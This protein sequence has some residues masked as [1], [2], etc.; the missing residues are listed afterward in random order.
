MIRPGYP[1]AGAG[2]HQAGRPGMRAACETSA[3]AASLGPGNGMGAAR[4][5]TKP[6]F[7]FASLADVRAWQASYESGGHQSWHRSPDL[8]AT[9]F[10]A[11]LG[12][13]DVTRWP[14]ARSAA[15]T[16]MWRSASSGR[17]AP[18]AGPP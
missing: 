16:R 9:A 6:L 11:F 10:A 3:L 12:C 17:M 4:P 7:P 18:S 15:A 8:T 2:H 5:V 14:G 13:T 1:P